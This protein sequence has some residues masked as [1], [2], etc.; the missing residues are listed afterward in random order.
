MSSFKKYLSAAA[1]LVWV[2]CNAPSI[3]AAP[4]GLVEGHL[5]IVSMKE[6]ELAGDNVPAKATAQN[7]D[8]YPLVILSRD[9]KTE[10]AR[11]T[12][13][14]NGNYRVALPPGDY[15]LDVQDRARKHVRA[16]PQ[17]FTVGSNQTVRV[18]MDMDTGIR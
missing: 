14:P 18:D 16:K 13:G 7:Y 2:L 8:D 6:V 12:A 9:G 15:L 10:V 4:P 5:K 1:C 11:L 3:S 17:S